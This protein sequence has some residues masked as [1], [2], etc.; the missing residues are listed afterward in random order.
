MNA[1]RLAHGLCIRTVDRLVSSAGLTE[2][3]GEDGGPFQVLVNQHSGQPTGE[4]RIFT[5]D[6]PVA[7]AV[8][9]G[10][11]ADV[12]GVITLDSHMVFAFT[13]EES[14][15][16]HFTLDSVERGDLDT[17]AFHL[18]L[19]P[20]VDMGAH[21]AYTDEVY[22]PLADVFAK[23]SAIEGITAAELGPRQR[24]IMSAYMMVGRA[25]PE[26]YRQLDPQVDAFLDQFLA[27][28]K[29]GL[30]PATIEDLAGVDLA[31]R[32]RRNR[33]FIFNPSVDPVWHHIIP[34]VGPE[35]SELIRAN[36]QH[37]EIIN[38]VHA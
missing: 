27:L 5:G 20:R 11:W 1:D 32:D 38:E 18:D 19:I 12:P 23:G 30:S 35:G 22:E 31:E 9:A 28:A 17:H 10:I 25:T 2:A 8:Y 7:K 33:S 6:G 15:A 4:L 14:P 26:A 13:P 37:N 21:L 3:L 24:S 16:P 29:D 34:L 36:L